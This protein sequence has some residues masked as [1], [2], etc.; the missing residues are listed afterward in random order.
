MGADS[1]PRRIAKRL[2]APLLGEGSYARIQAVAK[3]RDIASGDWSE[4][5]IDL[6]AKTLRPG[7]QAIDIGANFGLWSYHM[8]RAV[9]PDGHVY[10]FEPIPFT[11]RTFRIVA[12]KLGFD[13]AVTLYEAGAGE[14]AGEVEFTIPVNDS[15]AMTAGMVHMGRDDSRPGREKHFDFPKT[16][17]IRR[18]VHRIDDTLPALSRL[19]LVKCDIEGADLF[20]MRGAERTLAQHRPV[21]VIEINPWFL[22]G[23]GLQV[24][25]VTG[26][27]GGLGYRCYRYADQR[28]EPVGDDD[29]VEDNWV[30]VHPENADRV[31]DLI[32]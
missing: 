6:C 12:R 7:E 18:P 19:S 21:V 4:P 16:R 23:F 11:A 13:R 20:A 32:A 10:A 25:D 5:E 28:L 24:G 29:I 1:L 30:F 9:G 31:A 17:T 8:A 3:A 2:L 15:G 26:F 14:H 27:F 22:T